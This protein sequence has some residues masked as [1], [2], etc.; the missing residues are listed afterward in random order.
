MR[1]IGETTTDGAIGELSRDS[2]PDTVTTDVPAPENISPQPLSES[3]PLSDTSDL[4]HDFE[5]LKVSEEEWE[6]EEGLEY[7]DSDVAVHG[8][9]V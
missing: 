3:Q 6:K 4:E 1:D 7:G 9:K 2:T 8:S 5:D